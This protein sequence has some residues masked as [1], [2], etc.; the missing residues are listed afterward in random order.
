MNYADDGGAQTLRT[1]W[2]LG[3]FYWG[4]RWSLG[5]WCELRQDFRNFR[6]D[7]VGSLELLSDH[8]PVETG[9]TVGDLMRHYRDS[10]ARRAG[11]ET[12]K[13]ME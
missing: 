2:P 3:L 8:Y 5:A 9:R 6:L 10:A 1:V 13:E 4:T 12:D 7:R 11:S